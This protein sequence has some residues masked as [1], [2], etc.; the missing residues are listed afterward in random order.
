[1]EV[2]KGKVEDKVVLKEGKVLGA[3]FS[4]FLFFSYIE[5]KGKISDKVVSKEE[6]VLGD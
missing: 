2:R 3:F 5:R 4:F 1:M 6:Y